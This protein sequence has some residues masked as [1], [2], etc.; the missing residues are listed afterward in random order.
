MSGYGF[1]E[2]AIIC[3]AGFL[4]LGLPVASPVFVIMIYAKVRKIEQK[5]A[6]GK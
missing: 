6:Q 1:P 4:G 5:L 2:I 3:L